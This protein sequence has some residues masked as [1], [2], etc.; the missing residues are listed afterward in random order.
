MKIKIDENEQLSGHANPN[1]NILIEDCGCWSFG[2]HRRCD[3]YL[4]R[5][6]E[7]R[8]YLSTPDTVIKVSRRKFIS[9]ELSELESL[10]KLNF[11]DKSAR[12]APLRIFHSNDNYIRTIMPFYS[13]D[14]VTDHVGLVGLDKQTAV[15][16]LR[17]VV[18]LFEQGYMIYDIGIQNFKKDLNNQVWLIDYNGILKITEESPNPFFPANS[19]LGLC[20]TFILLYAY[21]VFTKRDIVLDITNKFGGTYRNN[22]LY[23]KINDLLCITP[24]PLKQCLKTLVDC[25]TAHGEPFLHAMKA[26][27]DQTAGF[28]EEKGD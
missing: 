14:I 2:M 27:L 19:M 15:T 24:E 1:Q 7:S 4:G 16:M 18:F 21:F 25:D 9:I 8:C 20:S 22:Q 10:Y 5:G 11:P 17:L 26:L 12:L 23:P 6:G 28:S 13:K 3:M